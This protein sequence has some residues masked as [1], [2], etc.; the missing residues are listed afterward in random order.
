MVDIRG[1]P[2]ETTQFFGFPELLKVGASLLNQELEV[3]NPLTNFLAQPLQ[4]LPRHSMITNDR[5]E[6]FL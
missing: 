2:S 1:K 6:P 3:A 5:A 4:L